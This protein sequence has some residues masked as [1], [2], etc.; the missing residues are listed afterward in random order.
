MPAGSFINAY[1]TANGA[2]WN[3]PS[4]R[5]ITVAQVFENAAD[6]VGTLTKSGVG[7]LTLNG[8]NLYTGLTTVSEGTITLGST[9]ALGTEDAGTVVA[10]GARVAFNGITTGASVS[11]AFTIAGFGPGGNSGVLNMGGNKSI[12]LTGPITVTADSLIY[13]NGGSAFNITSPIGIS[14]TDVNLTL[15][16]DNGVNS[17]ITSPISLGTGALIKTGGAGV[18]LSGDN[19]YS[20]GTTI[21]GG[22]LTA[23][24]SNNA[25]GSG[26]VNIDG[27]LRVAVAAG[28]DVSNAITVTSTAGASGR[29]TI[30]SFGASGTATISGP[31]NILGNPTAG[32]LLLGG[33]GTTLHL[34]GPI[35]AAAS[36]S[37]RDGRV[38]Y[39]GGGTGYSAILIT[40]TAVVGANDGIAT[41]A[42]VS[43]GGSQVASLDLNGFNQSLAGVRQPS[44]W[45][46]TVG[47][48]STTSDSVLT[49][50]GTSSFV[51]RIVDVIGTGTRKVGLTVASGDLTLTGANTHT[52]GTTVNQGVLTI[53]TGGVI[54]GATGPLSVNNTN[55]DVGNDTVVNL[56]TAANTTVGTLSGS[57]ATPNSG[58][59][60]ATINTSS[61]LSLTVNQTAD[62]T[63]G[64]TIAGAGSFVLGSS[65]TN[66][67]TLTGANTYTGTTQINAGVLNLGS[68]ETAGTSGPLGNQLANAVDT[69]AFGGGTLQ[70]SAANQFDYSGRFSTTANQAYRVDTNGQNVTWASNLTSSSGSLAKIGAGVLTLSGVNTYTGSTAVTAG[71]LSVTGSVAGTASVATTAVLAGTGSVAG[72]TTVA[73]T[74]VVSPG[75]NNVGTL[76]FGSS[77]TLESGSN[78]AVGLTGNGV[79]DKVNVT[80]TLTA[81]GT[82]TVGLENGYVPVAGATFDIADA[83]AIAGTPT[84]SLPT[85]T[86]GLQWNTDSFSTMGQISVESSFVDPFATWASD[87]GLQGA[88]A[89]RAADP[90]GDGVNNLL[91]FATNSNPTNGS[92]RA[93]VYGK[94]H[95]IGGNSVLT[96]TVATRAAAT[97]A[98][99]GSKQE[100]TKDLVKY[101]IEGSDDLSTWNTVVVTEVEGDDAT[102]VRSAIEPALPTLDS[103]WEWHTFRT[104]G[105]A[106]ADNSDYIRLKVTEAAAQ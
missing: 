67:L 25:L 2:K 42:T 5:D 27:G 91:E 14:G 78:Y 6:Q 44:T 32:G 1:L 16:T 37:Q 40:G 18:T 106:G 23:T 29:G 70:Y 97:F 63:F 94:V 86:Q 61:G 21:T 49:T 102:S 66:A 81:N 31:I 75:V 24:T 76:S 79:N 103:G 101:T 58:V 68:A 19:S 98:S 7:V 84:F 45:A 80:G 28:L 3:V 30:E 65:S 99:N 36:F 72:D 43:L 92:S 55:T 52:G 47:N 57:I 34:A 95:M 20:G 62:A 71:T 89:E 90:D 26:L 69:I 35:T 85:L 60:T 17:T 10:N 64:G 54:S 33:V 12:T 77:L 13:A 46:A 59:N 11:E 73:T 56:S 96:Y 39:S 48:S 82:I 50:T 87:N 15:Q 88:D 100:A 53:G 22:V 8:A 93:R 51:G 105:D 74:A 38:M 104:D 41:S 83:A 4:G 9:T